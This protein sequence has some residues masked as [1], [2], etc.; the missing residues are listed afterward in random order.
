MGRRGGRYR[1]LSNWSV[2]ILVV[3][4]GGMLEGGRNY[5]RVRYGAFSMLP[6]V[7]TNSRE[8]NILFNRSRKRFLLLYGVSMFETANTNIAKA[9][10]AIEVPRKLELPYMTC[11][12]YHSSSLSSSITL[13]APFLR[14]ESLCSFD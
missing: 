7:R 1:A 4:G 14:R 5:K 9:T 2:D 12:I 13:L 3:C 11:P 10:G 6:E 8:H